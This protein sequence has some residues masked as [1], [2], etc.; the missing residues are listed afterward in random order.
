[1]ENYWFQSKFFKKPRN[2]FVHLVV[3]TVN[4]EDLPGVY[5][6]R[7]RW[8]HAGVDDALRRSNF[9]FELGN[10]SVDMTRLIGMLTNSSS[11]VMFS[12]SHA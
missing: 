3:M 7:S 2:A 9:G 6:R 1:M 4:D 5:R 10:D 12:N 11:S 8:I